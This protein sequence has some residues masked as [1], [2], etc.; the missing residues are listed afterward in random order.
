MKCTIFLNVNF[1]P[2]R[3]L[4]HQRGR[5]SPGLRCGTEELQTQRVREMEVDTVEHLSV[6]VEELKTPRGSERWTQSSIWVWE[7]RS[8]RHCEGQR[9]GDS[10][11]L[12]CESWGA[13]DTERVRDVETVEHLSV[14]VEELKTLRGQRGGDSWALECESWGAED[15]ERVREVDTVEHL[16]VTVE[17]LQ[18]PRALERW[19]Q[20]ST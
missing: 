20:S 16:S 12:E 8:W 19:T 15:T 2:N 4:H 7:L 5:H 6:R 17:E 3:A 11:A 18:T 1:W 9:G 13:E 10:R 14:R